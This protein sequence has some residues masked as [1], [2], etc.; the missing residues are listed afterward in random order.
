MN[1]CIENT[2]ILDM[3]VCTCNRNLP[4]A[5]L[6]YLLCH[7]TKEEGFRT[8]LCHILSFLYLFVNLGATHTL[9]SK[10]Q[11]PG[12]KMGAEMCSFVIL[13]GKFTI[14][15]RCFLCNQHPARGWMCSENLNDRSK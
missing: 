5:V 3:S 14:I 6:K 4:V 1:G 15:H 12:Q 9:E 7:Y 13:R 8:I 2:L 11:F 10:D